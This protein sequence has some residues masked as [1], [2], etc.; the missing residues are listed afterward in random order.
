MATTL[1]PTA[2]EARSEQLTPSGRAFIGNESVDARSGETF[3]KRSP[4]DG[5][6]L[7]SVAAADAADVDDAVRAARQAFEHGVW[8]ALAPRDRKKLLLQYAD[9]IADAKDD[10]ALLATLEMGKPIGDALSEVDYTVQCIAYYAEAIDKVFG[11]IGPTGSDSL[12]LVTKEPAGVVG[13]VTPWN[14]PLLMPAWKLGPALGAGNSVVLKPAEQ[15]PLSAIR[16]GIIAAEAGVPAGVLNVVPG[17]GET[18]G[19]AVGRHMDVDV[20]GFTGSGEVG[21]L[22]LRYAGESNMK[23]VWLECGGKSP[24]VVLADAPDLEAA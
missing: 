11:E 15:T 7:A 21:K 13:A 1:D 8:A 16:L 12:T 23:Q 9:R 14:Y 22:F 24:N 2:W 6:R 19:Q 3:E 5:R 18:A 10:L 4:V 20:V 17:Y